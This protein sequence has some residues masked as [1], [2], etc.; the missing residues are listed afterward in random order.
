MCEHHI[1]CYKSTGFPKEASTSDYGY[2]DCVYY[3]L[4]KQ[5]H[6]RYSSEASRTVT[7]VESPPHA[8][9]DTVYG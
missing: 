8:S 9:T 6:F 5:Y 3:I 2:E 7:R 4:C 1:D